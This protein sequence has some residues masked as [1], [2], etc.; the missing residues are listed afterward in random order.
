MPVIR[1]LF[2]NDTKIFTKTHIEEFEVNNQGRE[3]LSEKGLVD[4]VS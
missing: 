3:F 4:L 1:I 2:S